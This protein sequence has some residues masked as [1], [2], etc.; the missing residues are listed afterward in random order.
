V[1]GCQS[2]TR[3]GSLFEVPAV[4]FPPRGTYTRD[5]YPDW[6]GMDRTRAFSALNE[7][8]DRVILIQSWD[9]VLLLHSAR[10]VSECLD[11]ACLWSPWIGGHTVLSASPTPRAGA[12]CQ[13][14]ASLVPVGLIQCV[15]P[16]RTVFWAYGVLRRAWGLAPPFSASLT[17]PWPWTTYCL[18]PSLSFPAW[19]DERSGFPWSWSCIEH[20]M[21]ADI[22]S[23]LSVT[24]Q[25]QS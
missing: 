8:D 19:W 18:S 25:L 24:P 4:G 13:C 5:V 6:T 12:G 21:P 22:E 3:P 2:L 11:K 23:V 10:Q 7:W 14:P 9:E 15:L 16:R 1:G 20:I 17:H